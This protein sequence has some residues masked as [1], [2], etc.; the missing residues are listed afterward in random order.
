[1][2]WVGKGMSS[3]WLLWK[4]KKI[5]ESTKSI[6]ILLAE[7]LSA[8]Q[9]ELCFFE[10][11][12]KLTKNIRLLSCWENLIHFTKT[13]YALYCIIW[14]IFQFWTINTFHWSEWS[15]C[16][17]WYMLLWAVR[18]GLVASVLAGGTG[19]GPAE[20]GGFLWMIKL[21]SAHFLWRGS[22]AVGPTW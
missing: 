6:N 7:R 22:K 9:E 1:M 17:K 12:T 15:K 18:V 4:R 10:L 5:L 19:S 3:G 11:Y 13:N 20:A 16:F 2:V 8:S 21:R 14:N